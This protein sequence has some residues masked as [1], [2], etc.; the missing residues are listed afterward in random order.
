MSKA[1]TLGVQSSDGQKRVSV[2]P[3]D[4]TDALY[5]NVHKAFELNNMQFSLFKDMQKKQPIESS[6]TKSVSSCGLKHGDRLFLVSKSATLFKPDAGGS[7]SSSSS[8]MAAA[9]SS[10]GSSEVKPK[11]V[12]VV[13]ED[14]IDVELAK[15]DG[16]IPRFV[17]LKV[18]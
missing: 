16:K 8:F 5:K 14:Q 6:R 12:V 1:I 3:I 13:K 15:I 17:I 18:C 7:S 10:S 2:S 4:K 11:T 9:S